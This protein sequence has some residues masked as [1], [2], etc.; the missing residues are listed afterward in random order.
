MSAPRDQSG[1][2]PPFFVR[3]G[4]LVVGEHDRRATV[5]YFNR[6]EAITHA[7]V[8]VRESGGGDVVVLNEHGKTTETISITLTPQPPL[9]EQTR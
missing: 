4:W 2:R 6:P 3:P 5:A 1:A 9:R 7:I 8:A